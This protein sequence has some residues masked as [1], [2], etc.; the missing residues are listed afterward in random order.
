MGAVYV[1]Y[2]FF[3]V[4]NYIMIVSYCACLLFGKWHVECSFFW[5]LTVAFRF[6]P[7]G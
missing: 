6:L 2:L 5:L 1:I 4:F 7:G 3:M